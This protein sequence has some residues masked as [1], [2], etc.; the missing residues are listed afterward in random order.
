M[1]S[2]ACEAFKVRILECKLYI[3][4]VKLSSSV[5]LAHAKAL[6]VGNVKGPIRRALCK[7]F[8]IPAGNLNATQ[9]NLFNGQ[10]P[11]RLVI[12]CVGNEVL[13]ELIRRIRSIVNI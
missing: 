9:E 11:T 10:L 8:E 3:R 7:T 6:E 13:T 1:S 12:G 2:A 5:F 4:K